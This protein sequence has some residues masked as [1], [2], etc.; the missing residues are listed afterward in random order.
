MPRPVVA[1]DADVLVPI[2]ACDFLLTAVDLGLYEPVVSAKVLD[3]IER[4]LIEDF[5]RLNPAAI[6]WRL[7]AMRDA[8]D[9]QIIHGGDVEVPEAINAKDRHV[10][11]AALIGEAEILTTNDTLLRHEADHA[12]PHL[13]ALSLDEFALDLW[14]RTPDGVT[15]VIDALVSKRTNPPITHE[16]MLQSLQGNMPS[17][18]RQLRE[19]ADRPGT[20]S[21]LC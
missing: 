11:A 4:T 21:D 1:L 15:A 16:T 18:I 3:E 7:E 12:L 19:T 9:D 2:I 20:R 17:L 6:H 5:P 14:R 10:I 13:R 8:L